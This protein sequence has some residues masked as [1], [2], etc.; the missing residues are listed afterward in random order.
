MEFLE[1]KH[2]IE[3]IEQM[4]GFNAPERHQAKEALQYLQ[5]V[6]GND[7]LSRAAPDPSVASHPI[8]QLLANY[9][10]SSRRDLTRFAGYLR[11]LE[12]SENLTRIVVRLHD[13]TR[14]KHDA[15][16]IKA[17]AG[18]VR[19]GLQACFEPTMPVQ[20]NQKQPD[21]RLDSAQTGETLFLEVA[22]QNIAK[23]EREAEEAA[24]RIGNLLNAVVM[25]LY[26]KHGN[27]DL[28]WAGRL[29]RTPSEPHLQE[30]LDK[31]GDLARRAVSE[32]TIVQFRDEG[33][34][35]LV[36]CHAHRRRLFD[37]WCRKLGMPEGEYCGTLGPPV[38]TNDLERL[39]QKIEKEQRQLPSHAMNAI[40]I[41]DT[42]VFSKAQNL[43][44]LINEVEEEVYKHSHVAIVILHSEYIG[45]G[46]GPPM[47]Q[48]GEHRYT[49]REIDGATEE[50]LLL[51]NRYSRVRLSD[52]LV[53]KF[54]RVF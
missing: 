38:R 18:L 28:R 54:C 45:D 39:K 22:V 3:G 42:I 51:L 33:T 53:A 41:L 47:F 6:L 14:F 23:R 21:V 19:E 48:K 29:Y 46:E 27:L 43:K 12:G 20:D 11:T 10:P 24:Q 17:A 26:N 35:D 50:N 1:W 4:E 25:D 37:D 44:N 8:L 7:F 5:T 15:L 30:I 31:I 2:H 16:V 9:A 34:L 32:E 36:F 49:H 40:L 52:N 13:A